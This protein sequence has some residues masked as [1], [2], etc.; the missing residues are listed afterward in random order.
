MVTQKMHKSRSHTTPLHTHKPCCEIKRPV[1]KG[2]SRMTSRKST[3]S[4]PNDPKKNDPHFWP[5]AHRARF[6]Q[7]EKS[8]SRKKKIMENRFAHLKALSSF[9]TEKKIAVE[10]VEKRQM[11]KRHHGG[12]DTAP[13]NPFSKAK[14]GKKPQKL[15][16]IWASRHVFTANS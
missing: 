11:A 13:K 14:K 8:D 9:T 7:N 15:Y 16:K 3:T 4:L 5:C 6:V 10:S 2:R 1:K 12:G